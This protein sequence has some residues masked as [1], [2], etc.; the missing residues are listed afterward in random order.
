MQINLTINLCSLLML[1]IIVNCA[2]W[3]CFYKIIC[4]TMFLNKLLPNP[5][6]ILSIKVYIF[7]TLNAGDENLFFYKKIKIFYFI[8]F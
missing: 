2:I 3:F 8:S 5:S 7:H 6:T 1:S 4:N